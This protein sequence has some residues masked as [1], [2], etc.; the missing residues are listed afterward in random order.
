MKILVATEETQG[1]RQNDFC[2]AEEGEIVTFGSECADETVDGSCGC[3]RALR[4]VR[5]RKATT[6][7]V[8]VE[9]P[10]IRPGDLARIVAESLV[11]GGWYPGVEQAHPA[12]A[13]HARR[14]ASIALTYAE[15]T[16]LERRDEKFSARAWRPNRGRPRRPRSPRAAPSARESGS[17]SK[18]AAGLRERLTLISVGAGHLDRCEHQPDAR[19]AWSRRSP[20]GSGHPGRHLEPRTP[21]TPRGRT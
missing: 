17:A 4:G 9:R 12:A 14:L 18:R 11:S 6:T 15:G 1:H 3:R 21:P 10:G 7:F 2:W 13:Q 20:Q 8:V 16:V 19:A 5:S